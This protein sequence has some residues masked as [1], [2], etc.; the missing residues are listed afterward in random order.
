VAGFSYMGYN[1]HYILRSLMYTH[2]ADQQH[3]M[4]TIPERTAV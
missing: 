2:A 3:V 4:Y 1:T